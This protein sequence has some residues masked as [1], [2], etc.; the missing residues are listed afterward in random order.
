MHTPSAQCIVPYLAPQSIYHPPFSGPPPEFPAIPAMPPLLCRPA[1]VEWRFS[2]C[3]EQ[4][5]IV[6]RSFVLPCCF[7]AAPFLG[8][9]AAWRR[10]QGDIVVASL[11]R[12]NRGFRMGFMKEPQRVNVLLSRARNGLIIFGNSET[13]TTSRGGSSSAG[14]AMWRSLLDRMTGKQLVRDGV[15]VRCQ[16]HGRKAMLVSPAG[17]RS[18]APHGGCTEPC[19][20]TLPCGHRCPLSCHAFD[21]EHS[22]VECRVPQLRSCSEGHKLQTTCGA[23][24]LA[25]GVHDL[26]GVETDTGC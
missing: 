5:K 26:P 14:A 12:S 4:Q 21:P 2:Q 18:L 16:N 23:A 17:F 25:A 20:S 6:I 13:F 3:S 1:L 15:P 24:A 19:W 10:Q 11:V 8:S 22:S 9:L 7:R